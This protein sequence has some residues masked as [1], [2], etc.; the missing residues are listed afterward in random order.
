MST[1]YITKMGLSL[2]KSFVADLAK[3]S[4][5]LLGKSL[6]SRANTVCGLLSD[7]RNRPSL[8]ATFSDV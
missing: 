4:R 8:F 6:G 1:D 5:T 2:N 7:P 3:Q